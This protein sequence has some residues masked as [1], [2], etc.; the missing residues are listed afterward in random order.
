MGIV[1]VAALGVAAYALVKAGDDGS[2]S[3]SG[4][5]QS[6]LS[7]LENKVNDLE[8]SSATDGSVS[9]LKSDVSDLSDQVHKL[10]SANQDAVTSQDFDALKQQVADLTQAVDDLQ[11]QP[12]P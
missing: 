6:Q 12:S 9:K 2:Q 3:R 5:S 4:V 11:N 7:D 10:D 1:S 8:D